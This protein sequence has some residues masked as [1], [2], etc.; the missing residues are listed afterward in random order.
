[1]IFYLNF[2]F[3]SMPKIKDICKI[4]DTKNAAGNASHSD[5]IRKHIYSYIFHLSAKASHV[6]VW[7]KIYIRLKGDGRRCRRSK[8][9]IGRKWNR[10]ARNDR[11][12][13]KGVAKYSRILYI[14]SLAPRLLRKFSAVSFMMAIVRDRWSTKLRGPSILSVSRGLSVQSNVQLFLS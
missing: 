12:G 9:K 1:M 14:Y 2:Y 8:I 5:I 4:V 11:N 7:E 6:H 3:S 10:M 13:Y